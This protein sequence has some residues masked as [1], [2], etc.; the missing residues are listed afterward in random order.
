MNVNFISFILV[1]LKFSKL[2]LK[3]IIDEVL[4]SLNYTEIERKLLSNKL[5]NIASYSFSQIKG[6]ESKKLKKGNIS[7]KI[8]IVYKTPEIF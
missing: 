2:N 7:N 8:Y 3:I 5:D 1:K 4:A 6:M